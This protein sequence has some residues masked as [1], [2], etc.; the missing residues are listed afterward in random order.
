MPVPFEEKTVKYRV[1]NSTAKLEDAI[2]NET[3]WNLMTKGYVVLKNFIPKDII[4]MTLDNWKAFE[5]QYPDARA[6]KLENDIISRSPASSLKKSHGDAYSPYGIGLH[7][8]VTR[9]LDDVL[10]MDLGVTYCYTRKYDRGAYLKAHSDRPSCEISSTLCLGYKTDDNKPWKIYIDNSKNWLRHRDFDQNWNETQGLN[11][12][13]RAKKK[14]IVCVELEV[15]DMM[16]YLGPNVLHW[17]DYLLGDYSYH[18]FLH[19]YNVSSGGMNEFFNKLQHVSPRLRELTNQLVNDKGV[20]NP[21]PLHLDGRVDH[22]SYTDDNTLERQFFLTFMHEGWQRQFEEN[23]PDGFTVDDI[24][25]CVNYY[26][27]N[28]LERLK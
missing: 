20:K 1:K 10:D 14:G 3:T 19:W 11:H 18:A 21:N 26:F 27:D 9:K 17:R 6:N 4:E 24:A 7:R 28:R 8:Y 25:N 15:G 2:T 5:T 22:W 13:E 12:R 23:L 16:L